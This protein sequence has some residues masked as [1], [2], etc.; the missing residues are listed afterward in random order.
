M[1]IY[2]IFIPCIAMVGRL[3]IPH[4]STN[5]YN[6]YFKKRTPQKKV[7]CATLYKPIVVFFFLR[8]SSQFGGVK[9]Y[10]NSLRIIGIT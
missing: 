9:N 4:A 10:E 1:Y 3:S 5:V 6:R 8:L 2:S 7:S